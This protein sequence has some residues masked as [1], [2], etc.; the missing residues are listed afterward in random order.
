MEGKYI[1]K[2]AQV[3][4]AQT[5]KRCSIAEKNLRE[6]IE[7]GETIYCSNGYLKERKRDPKQCV[8]VFY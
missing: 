8:Y 5:Q 4:V 6:E 7:V 3:A 1:Q 2:C